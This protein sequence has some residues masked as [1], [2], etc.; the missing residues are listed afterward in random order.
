MFRRP[1]PRDQ[2]ND[3]RWSKNLTSVRDEGLQ[4]F[5]E[6]LPGLLPDREEDL[7]RGEFGGVGR[8]GRPR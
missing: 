1:L 3:D 4:V 8:E 5:R 2:L 7:T 6:L